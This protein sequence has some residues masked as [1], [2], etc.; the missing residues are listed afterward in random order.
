[1]NKIRNKFVVHLSIYFLITLAVI[2]ISPFIG[3]EAINI[4]NIKSFLSEG[5]ENIDSRIFFNLRLPRVLL[6]FLA[7]GTLALVG[8]V[9]QAI[10]R[11]PLATPYTLGITGGAAIGAYLSIAFDIFAFN[12][13]FFSSVQ[14]FAFVG[15]GITMVFIYYIAKKPGGVS[16]TSLLLA[17]VTIGILSSAFLLLIRYL[18]EP[19]LLVSMDRWTMGS[20]DVVGYK[21]IA[22]ILP[23][24]IASVGLLFMQTNVLNHLSFGEEM[25]KG[26]GVDVKSV[27]LI[28]FAAGSVATASIVSAAG[29]IAFVGLLVPHIIRRISG[30]DHRIILPGVF[31]IGGGFLVSCDTFARIVISPSE[32]PTGIITALTGGVFFIYLLIRKL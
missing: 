25:A 11:N 5:Q 6:G 15:A 9:F 32:M 7:G 8:A 19:N 22:V 12:I 17:G 4:G 14:L 16:M 23:I 18:A 10:L 29:P 21:Q 3:S 2:C 28:C 24:L 1:M 20:L 26:H 13:A 31:L 30:Y 27:H